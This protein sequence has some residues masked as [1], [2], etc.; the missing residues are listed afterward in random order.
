MNLYKHGQAY[1]FFEKGIEIL[2]LTQNVN[3]TIFAKSKS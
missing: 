1:A 3:S 2:Y